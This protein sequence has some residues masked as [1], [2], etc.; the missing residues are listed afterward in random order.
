MC[1]ATPCCWPWPRQACRPST[2]TPGPAKPMPTC[3]SSTTARAS[4]RL[5]QRARLPLQSADFA[6][7]RLAVLP[8]ASAGHANQPQHLQRYHKDLALT[9][10]G[11]ERTASIYNLLSQVGR[12]GLTTEDARQEIG[13][14]VEVIRKRPAVASCDASRGRPRSSACRPPL[15]RFG[16]RPSPSPHAG[17]LLQPRSWG[18]SFQHLRCSHGA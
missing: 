5:S 9:V 15:R 12:F 16:P 3:P 17:S 6:L 8:L 11:Y 7:T 4:G 14:I 1:I 2:S 18:G 10:G 13:R